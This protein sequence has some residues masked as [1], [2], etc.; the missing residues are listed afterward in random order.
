LADQENLIQRKIIISF[1]LIGVVLIAGSYFILQLSIDSTFRKLEEK[2]SRKE[3]ADIEV[4]IE[5]LIENQTLFNRDY[6]RWD[7]T[8]DAVVNPDV[9]P[10]YVERFLSYEQ[11]TPYPGADGML[12]F[13]ADGA[14][15]AGTLL[16]DTHEEELSI[17]KIILD[18]LDSKFSGFTPDIAVRDLTTEISGLMQT[19]EGLLLLVSVPIRN[20]E[21]NREPAGRFLVAHFLNAERFEAIARRA[22]VELEL[23]PA[24]SAASEHSSK[25]HIIKHLPLKDISGNTLTVVEI[26]TPRDISMAGGISIR[27]AMLFLSIAILVTIMLSWL[28]LRQLMVQPL[29]SLKRHVSY[30]RETG[31]LTAGY[32]ASVKDE[33]GT[34]ADEIDFLAGNLD[35]SRTQ[36]TLA[37]DQAESAS[38]AKS[39]FLAAMSHELRTPLNGVI[40]MADILMRSELTHQQ[41]CFVE[42]VMSSGQSLLKLIDDILNFSNMS[43]G[44][45]EISNVSFSV[46][47]LLQE[48]S[49]VASA[50]AQ[51]NG[52][53][54]QML[55]DNKL[56]DTIVADR[57]RLKQVLLNLLDNAVKF[58]HSGEVVLSIDCLDRNDGDDSN[59]LT[60]SFAV[61]DTGVGIEEE[62]IG[63][64]F[65][66]FSQ[67]DGSTTREFGGS[68]LGLSISKGLVEMMGGGITVRSVY[69]EGSEFRFIVQARNETLAATDDERSA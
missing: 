23:L 58:T 46:E 15:V 40:G 28:A 34:L 4:A 53:R 36:L 13:D 38:R 41:Q 22:R 9:L 7:D 32:H 30:M 5:H 42:A 47:T 56:P 29:L 24:M 1:L 10:H 18:E 27:N 51:E 21:N 43:S 66:T 3:V 14:F 12:M 48:V 26:R 60:L 37:R 55:S 52:L 20:S 63:S 39:E 50:A 67:A 45:M 57:Q 19:P 62:N 61:R 11:W 35:M 59:A 31:D 49:A 65:D 69:G 44:H 68:G 17:Q 54:Y 6:A 2:Q 25:S 16:D 33:V 8:Y 64:I